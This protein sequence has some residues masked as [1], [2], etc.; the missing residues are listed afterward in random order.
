MPQPLHVFRIP[1]RT[2]ITAEENQRILSDSSRIQCLEDFPNAI[3]HLHN[4]VAIE[5]RFAT[6][7]EFLQRQPWGVRS[8]K[9]DIQEERLFSPI[10]FIRFYPLNGLTGE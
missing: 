5:I 3:I 8:G 10:L 2:V 9:C 1:R 7:R 4:E 6:S